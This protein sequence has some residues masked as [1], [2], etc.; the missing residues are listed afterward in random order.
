MIE[1][2]DCDTFDN[3]VDDES[4][5]IK[6]ANENEEA[7]YEQLDS[8]LIER[9]KQVYKDFGI[10]DGLYHIE[11]WWPNHLR[12]VESDPTHFRTDL[13]L[14][15][16]ALLC[17]ELAPWR[18]VIHFYKG[19]KGSTGCGSALIG[20]TRILAQPELTHYLQ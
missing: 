16:Q 14:G 6:F 10:S 15:L 18:I 2:T 19:L 8:K 1:F 13:M 5:V 9:I 20:A 17:G 4:A 3:A 11:D 7:A 12:A